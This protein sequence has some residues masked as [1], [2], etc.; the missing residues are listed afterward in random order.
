MLAYREHLPEEFRRAYRRGL[1]AFL[2]AFASCI[3]LILVAQWLDMRDPQLAN[4]VFKG[5]GS[6]LVVVIIVAGLSVPRTS[7]RV[8]RWM[9][10]SGY[11][12]H[13]RDDRATVLRKIASARAAH[14]GST[15]SE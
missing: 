10:Q 11:A 4:H 9:T 2:G 13:W 5:I 14:A 7:V 3:P 6:V 8:R 12:V 1:F 15:Q